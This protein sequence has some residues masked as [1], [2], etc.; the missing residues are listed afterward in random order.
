MKSDLLFLAG[1]E[2]KGTTSFWNHQIFGEVFSPIVFLSADEH[3]Y[4]Q[5]LHW[6]SKST[7]QASHHIDSASVS[8]SCHRSQTPIVCRTLP[9]TLSLRLRMQ[10]YDNFLNPPNFRRSFF[11]SPSLVRLTPIIYRCRQA[12]LLTSKT[13]SPL[14]RLRHFQNPVLLSCECKGTT[15]FPNHQMFGKLFFRRRLLIM[16]LWRWVRPALACDGLDLLCP[17]TIYPQK[18]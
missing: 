10:R 5:A 14:M 17:E 16:I 6:A 7:W 2:C 3:S 12:M 15:T 18:G 4:E 1:C 8:I 13:C 11:S 9:T